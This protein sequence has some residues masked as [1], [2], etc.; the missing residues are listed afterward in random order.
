MGLARKRDMPQFYFD[1]ENGR[2]SSRDDTGIELPDRATARSAAVE[3][4]SDMAGDCFP[5]GDEGDLTVKVRDSLGNYFYEA[6]LSL[7]ARW[8]G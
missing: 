5:D 3:A 7:R 4:L 1:I 6:K 8:T 2:D